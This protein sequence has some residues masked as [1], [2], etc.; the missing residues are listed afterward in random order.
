MSPMLRKHWFHAV[1][2]LAKQ[3]SERV[4]PGNICTLD[5]ALFDWPKVECVN[6]GNLC[7]WV[8]VPFDLQT[9]KVE[10]VNPG[11]SCTCVFVPCAL[12]K[13]ERVNPG[14]FCTWDFVLEYLTASCE[15]VHG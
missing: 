14:N 9:K 15:S 5:F 8:L 13:V 3:I 11:N 7:T 12:P 2:I 4:N 1:N 10:R 6:P